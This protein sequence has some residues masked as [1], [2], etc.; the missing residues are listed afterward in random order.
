MVRAVEQEPQIAHL[1][2]AGALASMSGRQN[3]VVSHVEAR[4]EDFSFLIWQQIFKVIVEN[5]QRAL[6]SGETV[7]CE[8]ELLQHASCSQISLVRVKLVCEPGRPARPSSIHA[9]SDKPG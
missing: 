4:D 6:E 8:F 1:T 7:Q 5:E 2:C 9:G 3:D